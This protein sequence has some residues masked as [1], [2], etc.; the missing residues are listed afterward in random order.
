MGDDKQQEEPRVVYATLRESG[1]EDFTD[2]ECRFSDGQKFAAVR[3][4]SDFDGLAIQIR[5]CLN[6]T[7]PLRQIA[8]LV[9][10]HAVCE[11]YLASDSVME[12]GCYQ[13]LTFCRF[14]EEVRVALRDA[15]VFPD[16][17]RTRTISEVPS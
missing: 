15:S 8:A 13:S 11:R 12:A 6:S 10:A 7:A 5:D 3:V 1:G 16:T 9:E 2:I 17:D 4:S 14:Y